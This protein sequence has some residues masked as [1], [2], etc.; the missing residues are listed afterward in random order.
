MTAWQRRIINY[1]DADA[2][3]DLIN[4]LHGT[5]TLAGNAA[6]PPLDPICSFQLMK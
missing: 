4:E 1:F 6:P 5:W 3:V 2:D